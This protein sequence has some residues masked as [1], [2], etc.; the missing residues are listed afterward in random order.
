VAGS[1]K[2][3]RTL[4]GA[5]L[6]IGAAVALVIG[7]F[8]GAGAA[9]SAA[10]PQNTSPPTISGTPQSGQTLSGDKGVWNGSPTSYTFFWMRCDKKGGSCSNIS[11]ANTETYTLGSAD[12]GT[13][14][15]FK[16]KATNADGSTFATSVQTAVI[17]AAAKPAPPANTSPPTISG[18]AQE[19][20]VL[21]GA[22]GAW[23]GAPTSYTY[24]WMRC[25]KSGGSC[26]NISG[27]NATTYT[28]TSVDVG[29][30][31]RFKVKATNAAGSATATSAQTAVVTS[32]APPPGSTIQVDKVS[33][34]DLLVIDKL[35]FSPN[36]ARTR[37][38]IVARFH[39]SDLRGYSIQ[40]AL[41]YAIG[42]PYSWLRSAPEVPTDASGWATI[43]LQP[44]AAM[45]LQRGGA[46]VLF[47][48]ARKPGD[49][50][51]SGVS[52]RRLVQEG[53]SR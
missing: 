4:V 15:R 34:P 22:N 43:T 48:R 49:N 51:L 17:T 20:Q 10:A 37:G 38:P 29:N 11:G 5:L 35:S 52:T 28:L 31:L 23:S 2:R 42:L 24:F 21:T 45:P 14:I 44:T 6:A 33:L 27:A 3:R 50:L 19:G 32:A 1:V 39:V 18:N 16:V 8:A 7:V 41:V 9:A 46:L 26:A 25:S 30:T 53:I 36:P 13:T 47:V 40:G 12:V